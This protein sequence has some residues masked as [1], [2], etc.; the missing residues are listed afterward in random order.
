MRRRRRRFVLFV[1]IFITAALSYYF[2]EY[3]YQKELIE[4]SKKSENE[5]EKLFDDKSPAE[6]ISILQEKIDSL[7][8][9]IKVQE[10]RIPYYSSPI[11][12]YDRVIQIINLLDEKLDVNLDKLSSENINDF[13]MEKFQIKGEG[14][15]KYLFAL[16]NLFETSPELYKINIKEIKQIF[17]PNKDGKMEEKVLFNFTLDAFYTLNPE[18]NFDSTLSNKNLRT[19]FYISDL[20]E[21]LIKMEIPS[22]EEGLFEVDGAKLLAI[23]PDAVYLIDKKGNSFT[24]AEG[25][26]VYLGYLTKIDYQNHSCEFL[27]NKGGILERV[28]LQLDDKEIKR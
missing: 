20:F 15:F 2:V 4:L 23:M 14:K 25:D 6:L 1:L 7:E 10:K 21:S 22:N 28:S 8:S 24:L 18:F 16:I 3:S 12:V 27:L 13:R 5:N 19:V 17:S 26:E 11:Q 9:N